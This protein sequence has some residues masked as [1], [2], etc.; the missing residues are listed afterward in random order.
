[1]DA[2]AKA[3]TCGHKG[4]EGS[5]AFDVYIG[6]GGGPGFLSF[7]IGQHIIIIHLYPNFLLIRTQTPAW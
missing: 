7:D 6:P 5:G 1:M 4:A 2:T 3:D